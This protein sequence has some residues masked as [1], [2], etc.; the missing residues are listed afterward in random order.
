MYRKQRGGQLVAALY[1]TFYALKDLVVY[2]SITLLAC[3]IQVNEK[4]Y[5]RV[6]QASWSTSRFSMAPAVLTLV[7]TKT[8]PKT[9][10]RDRKSVV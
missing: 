3:L 4:R 8:D 1:A 5:S 7:K 2:F 9:S 6:H 10:V